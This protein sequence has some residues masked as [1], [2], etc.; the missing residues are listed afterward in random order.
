MS[1]EFI[2]QLTA[3][4]LS[5]AVPVWMAGLIAAICFCPLTAVGVQTQWTEQA[6]CVQMSSGCQRDR[7]FDVSH[8]SET[9][10]LPDVSNAGRQIDGCSWDAETAGFPTA[11][12]Q[13]TSVTFTSSSLCL[14][15]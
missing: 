4:V 7:Q 14:V 10:Q 1:N 2:S 6:A 13:Q 9:M 8:Q 15:W 11:S 12:C 3:V 5:V